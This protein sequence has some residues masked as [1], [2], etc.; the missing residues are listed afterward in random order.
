MQC[1]SIFSAFHLPYT[2]ILP[3]TSQVFFHAAVRVIVNIVIGFMSSPVL[4]L[5]FYTVIIL[6]REDFEQRV[7]QHYSNK[8]IRLIASMVLMVLQYYFHFH[9]L[10]TVNIRVNV[11]KQTKGT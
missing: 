3:P 9:W 4:Q 10:N 7:G 1:K 8:V 5:L 11:Q 2:Q 6:I